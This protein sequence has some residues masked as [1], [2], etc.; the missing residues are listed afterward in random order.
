MISVTNNGS[1]L[2]YHDDTVIVTGAASG[3]GLAATELFAS[4]GAHVIAADID[5]DP[6]NKFPDSL[7]GVP[8]SVTFT[9]LDVTDYELFAATVDAV[10]DEYGALDVLVNNAG[11]ARVGNLEDTSIEDRD[12]L[13]NVNINGVWNGCRAA[14]G[15]MK[16][17][18][19]G[20]I[21]N[22]SSSGGLLGTPKLATYALTKAA[23][24][25]FTR[26]LAGE[27][28]SNNVRVNTVC[29]GTIETSLSQS[30][31]DEQADPEAAR[32]SAAGATVFD[33]LGTPGEV[34]DAIAFLASDEASFITG[35]ALAV[36]GGTSAIL[37]SR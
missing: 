14:I 25:N 23:V 13:V 26:A 37:R 19:S 5:S 21:V 27:V 6:V 2:R 32:E 22:V 29:P 28:G 31:M 33:R 20:S 11:I 15:S 18:R 8:G 1:R 17:A 16:T 9:E 35:H 10:V 24:I 4:E 7:S 34:A 36:D 3:I 30:V 12:A